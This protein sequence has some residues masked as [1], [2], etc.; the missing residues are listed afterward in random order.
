MATPL[1]YACRD[2]RTKAGR[3]IWPACR[4][5]PTRWC[6]PSSPDDRRAGHPARRAR[7]PAAG[8]AAGRPPLLRAR[9]RG[10]GIPG[11]GLPAIRPAVAASRHRRRATGDVGPPRHAEEAGRAGADRPRLGRRG[12]AEGAAAQRS[13]PRRPRCCARAR[14]STWRRSPSISVENGYGRADTVMEPGEYA[15]RGGLVDLF[16]PGTAEPLRLDLFGDVLETIRSFD[17]MSQLTTGTRDEVV[18]LPV[19]EVLLDAGQHRALP[20]RLSRAVRRRRRRRHRSTRR[21]RRAS[22]MSAWSTGCRCSTAAGD[23]DRLLPRG[24]RHGRSPDQGSLRRALGADRGLLRRPREDRR[25]GRHVGRRRLQARAAGPALPQAVAVGQACS[26][27][28][29]SA[30]SPASTRRPRRRTRSISAA[31]ATRASPRRAP[32]RA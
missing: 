15:V 31:A 9:A 27:A 28:T 7:R 11:L 29:A 5:A 8:A 13:T 21:C 12:A 1:R 6:W 22:A 17:P 4:R 19:S 18:L 16:P 14:P 30:S 32:R 26:T 3:W 23:A 2:R 25:E 24:G 10:A 20:H